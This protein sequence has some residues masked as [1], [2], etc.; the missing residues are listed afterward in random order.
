MES[1]HKADV[2]SPLLGPL[3]SE[4]AV[5]PGVRGSLLVLRLVHLPREEGQSLPHE[6]TLAA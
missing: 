1:N 5:L 4:V 6:R 3:V 2:V